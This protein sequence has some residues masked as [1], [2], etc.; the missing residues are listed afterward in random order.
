M[1]VCVEFDGKQREW[2]FFHFHREFAIQIGQSG[3]KGARV[4]YAIA[5]MYLELVLIYDWEIE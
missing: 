5:E 3:G 1:C 4:G 2:I